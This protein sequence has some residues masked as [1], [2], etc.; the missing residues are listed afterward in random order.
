MAIIKCNANNLYYKLCT[1]NKVKKKEIIV[2]YKQLNNDKIINND[3]RIL[4]NWQL[5]VIVLLIILV[6]CMIYK[7][8]KNKVSNRLSTGVTR[9]VPT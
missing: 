6:L 8:Y 2:V 9:Q 5:I 4:A 7:C 1:D 3:E